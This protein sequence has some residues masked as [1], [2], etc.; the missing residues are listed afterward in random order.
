MQKCFLPL[1]Y[2]T[3][4]ENASLTE[5]R[6]LYYQVDSPDETV[7]SLR[8]VWSVVGAPTLFL[9]ITPSSV[10]L[11]CTE[12][13]N[14]SFNWKTFNSDQRKGS[15]EIPGFDGNFSFAIVFSSLIEYR[16]ANAK[17]QYGFNAS[18]LSNTEM[19]RVYPLNDLDWTFDTD[20]LTGR[21]D[22]SNLT[23][24]IQV[25]KRSVCV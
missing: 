1:D 16:D 25:K 15:A 4:P 7:S 2:Q 5:P 12:S 9:S 24:T 22:T 8:Y 13:V 11:N 3:D 6:V 23:W 14:S 21:S 18:D 19:Y 10:D 17:A 20:K